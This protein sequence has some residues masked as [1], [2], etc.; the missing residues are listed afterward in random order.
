MESFIREGID[1]KVI[2][3][4]G[5]WYTYNG[6]KAMGLNGI[7]ALFRDTEGLFDKLKGEVVV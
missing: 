1:K 4:A 6:E 5:A 3:Q 7:K 2:T